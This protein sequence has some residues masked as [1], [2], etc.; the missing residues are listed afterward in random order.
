M[1]NCEKTKNHF[2]KRIPRGQGKYVQHSGERENTKLRV[3]GLFLGGFVLFFG[4]HS[5]KYQIHNRI[6]III[7]FLLFIKNDFQ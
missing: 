2:N 6:Y 4:Y 1:K 5:R 3:V 7:I